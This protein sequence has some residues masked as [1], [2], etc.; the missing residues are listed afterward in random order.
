MRITAR[1]LILVSA[2]A[3]ALTAQ[4]G[5]VEVEPTTVERIY[6]AA[7]R[8]MQQFEQQQRDKGRDV[9]YELGSLDERLTLSACDKPLAVDFS[10]DPMRTTRTTLL[11]S[12]QADRP[13]RLFLKT[14]VEIK[15]EGWIAAQPIGR[16][17]RLSRDMLEQTDV[18]INQRRRSGYTNPENMIGMKARRSINA[19]TSITPDMLMAPEAVSRGDRVIISA[20]NDVFSIQTRG[21]AVNGGRVGEQITVINENSG[22]R[23]RARIV[24]PGRVEVNI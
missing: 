13:W 16:G 20:G 11:V 1:F 5:S 23:V 9:D 4:G 3:W 17:E 8:F 6:Q 21:E 15:A 22:R 12:C 7:D 10:G 24:E 18:V 14:S 2:M 19:N